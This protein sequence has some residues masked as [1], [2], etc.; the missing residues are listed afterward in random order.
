MSEN[1]R[2]VTADEVYVA[3]ARAR[4]ANPFDGRTKEGRAWADGA[5]LVMEEIKSLLKGEWS[6]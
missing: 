4:N 1:E 2:P 3:V 6:A 5:W